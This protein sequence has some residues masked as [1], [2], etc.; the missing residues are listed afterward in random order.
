MKLKNW[1]FEKINNIDEPLTRLI[2]KTGD[3][4]QI[5]IIRNERGDIT[6]DSTDIKR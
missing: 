1:C 3:K 2:R 4:T 5:T 6:T